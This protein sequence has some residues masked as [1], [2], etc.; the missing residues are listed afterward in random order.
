MDARISKQRTALVLDQPFF[1]ALALRLKVVED[2]SCKTFWTD[3]VSIGYNPSYLSQLND[4]QTR[5]V[6]AHEV[7][8]VAGGHCWRQGDRDP[9][10]WND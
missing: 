9:D 6:L 1:G 2:P 7:L 8:H 10:L 4:L 5:G 3:S